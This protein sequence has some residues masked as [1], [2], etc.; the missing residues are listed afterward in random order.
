MSSLNWGVFV[1]RWDRGL[2]WYDSAFGT[3]RSR[4]RISPVPL[5][6]YLITKLFTLSV[7]VTK[8]DNIILTLFVL[9][10]QYPKFLDV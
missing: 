9:N 8:K 7:L 3:Q 2:A 5:N 4:I 1:F 10:E 6:H